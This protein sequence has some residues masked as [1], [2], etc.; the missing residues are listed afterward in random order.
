MVL[1][2]VVLKS[3]FKHESLITV[4]AR[5]SLALPCGPVVKAPAQFEI[6]VKKV[7]FE[8]LSCVSPKQM[9]G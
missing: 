8:K 2:S 4:V 1:H 7:F 5:P 6:N 3:R 9:L